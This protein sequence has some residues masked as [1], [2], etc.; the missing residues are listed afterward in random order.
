MNYNRRS[1][2]K[3]AG[4][5]SLSAA[6]MASL[7]SSMGSFLNAEAATTTGY[8]ALVCVFLLGGADNHDII[9]PYDQT[10]YDRIASIRSSLYGGYGASRN[11]GNLLPINPVNGSDFGSRQFAM[12][13]E[14]TGI[15]NLFESGKAA[16]VGNVGPLI[17]PVTRSNWENQLGLPKRL[18]SHNDQQSTWMSS[19][20]EGA[21]FGWGGRFADAAL[22]AGANT[23]PEFTTIT[24]L[25]NELF[26]TGENAAPFQIGLEGAVEVGLLN[27]MEDHPAADNLRHHFKAGDFTSNNL[28]QRDIA[29]IAD[30][31]IELNALYNESLSNFQPFATSFSKRPLSKQLK[32]IAETIA[33]RNNLFMS[34][35]VFFAAIGGFDTHGGQAKYLP[36][37]LT[38]LD[39]AVTSFYA[40]MEEI[41][42][43]SDVT[44]FTA[45]DFGRTLAVNGSGTDHGWGAH[46]F[47]VGNA[48]EGKRI[49]GDLPPPELDGDLDAGRGRLI[50]TTSVEQF[51]EP[52]GKWFGLNATEVSE[53]LPNLKNFNEHPAMGK[54]MKV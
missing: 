11:R 35:Q 42:L 6:G 25:G 53:A 38:Q 8:K 23:N 30:G 26:L 50:P 44:L 41:G 7:Q 49:Y 39:E 54:M 2:L 9:L 14:L 34:R 1:F 24:S 36:S 47:V 48:V 17:E 33:I 28:L 5:V 37:K 40:A 18:F 51:A 21:Q 29:N 45:S 10:S 31:S 4:A 12:P 52:L 13:P 22:S 20:P 19:A 46:H 3:G 43:G 27:A 15:R 16:V 32:A